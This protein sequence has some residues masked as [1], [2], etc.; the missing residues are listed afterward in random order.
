MQNESLALGVVKYIQKLYLEVQ[1]PHGF[2]GR[3]NI[4]DVSDKYTELL[5]K[6][7][8]TGI[9]QDNL[10]ELSDMF[11]VGQTVRCFIKEAD[12]SH[13]SGSNKKYLVSLNPKMV[14]K[15]V[16]SKNV[17]PHMVFVGSVVSVEDHGYILD[18]GVSRMNCFLPRDQVDANLDIGSLIPFTLLVP[19]PQ[20]NSTC[21]R[22]LKVTTRLDSTLSVL[23][24]DSCINFDCILPGTCLHASIV[25]KVTSTLVAEFSEH[26]I[27]I[28]RTH[29]IG[30][31]E[32][33]QIGANVIVCVILVD[34]STK[35]LT[36]SLL[37]HLVNPI[38]SVLNISD[39]LSKCSVGTRFSSSLVE[40]VNKRA[41]LVK[42]PKTNGFKAV[43]R[44]C[45]PLLAGFVFLPK[46]DTFSNIVINLR[47]CQSS[48]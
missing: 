45:K 32:D 43:I 17:K 39:M 6:S 31:K 1:L 13:T 19:D 37:P 3:V 21:E 11:R 10:V 20:V 41:I 12:S 23:N 34:P 27:S 8:E 22:V 16:I 9:I 15:A 40:R 28:S 26:F 7:A 44:V 38:P 36:G 29:Y 4:Y 48:Y 46:P 24:P 5:R 35:Q 18:A 14:N 25:K 47:M 33:Y 2:L 30:N 42:L